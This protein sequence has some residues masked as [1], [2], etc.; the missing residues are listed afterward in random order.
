[1]LAEGGL[2]E[3]MGSG[4]RGEVENAEFP[5]PWVMIGILLAIAA[6]IGIAIFAKMKLDEFKKLMPA[7]RRQLFYEL[8]KAH[9]LSRQEVKLL[10]GLARVHQLE[11]WALLFV[12]PE[13]FD[14]AKLGTL[15]VE[16]VQAYV[17]IRDRLFARAIS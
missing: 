4:F 5:I 9:G 11:N 1:M 17:S 15:H 2:L 10:V 8:C 13:R 12:Q 6:V 16:T 7:Q 3:H 14:S